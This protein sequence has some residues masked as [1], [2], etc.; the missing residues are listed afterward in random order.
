MTAQAAELLGVDPEEIENRLMDMQMEK[1][2][3]VK[4]SREETGRE[5]AA[6]EEPAKEAEEL[7][8]SLDGD[9]EAWEEQTNQG[10]QLVYASQYYYTELN[11]AKMLH[12]LNITGDQPEESIRKSLKTIQ[13]QEHIELDELQVQA[14]I[15]AVN[16][17]LLI[18]TGG[19]G[20]GKTT[21]INTI[22]RYFELGGLDILLAAPQA[23]R[24]S[25]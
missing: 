19:P 16:C 23:G 4:R 9:G 6:H 25:A 1:R 14:V 22:I 13:E 11:T 21:T 5:Q 24:P 17:G 3:V 2:L 20:T 8:E 12:D 10:S 18:I 15:E 7:P